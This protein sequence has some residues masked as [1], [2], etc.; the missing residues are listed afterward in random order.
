MIDTAQNK[1]TGGADERRTTPAETR[2][3]LL[4]TANGHQ[5]HVHYQLRRSARARR[6]G[7]RIGLDGLIV[8]LPQHA[9]L[10]QHQIEDAIRQH[11]AWVLSKLPHWQ[12]R[13]EAQVSQRPRLEDGGWL[14]FLG[15]RLTLRLQTHLPQGRTRLLRMGSAL[16][17]SG[18]ATHDQTLL[19]RAAH[20]WLRQQAMQVFSQ[21]LP[22]FAQALGRSPRSLSLSSART[23]WGSCTRD[24]DIRLNWRLIQFSPELIDYVIAHELAHLVEMNHGPRFWAQLAALMPDYRTHQAR[25]KAEVDVLV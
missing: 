24:G 1:H 3:S 15:E 25:L 21:R 5:Q 2:P 17:V 4:L 13:A 6:L 20:Q 9:R 22:P 10:N 7:L 14:P 19:T 23:R 18:P 16:W 12:A 8:T 11:S